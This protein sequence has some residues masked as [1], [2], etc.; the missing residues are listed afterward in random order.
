MDGNVFAVNDELLKKFD[1]IERRGSPRSRQAPPSPESFATI[2]YLKKQ[3]SHLKMQLA[4]SEER[5][6][7]EKSNTIFL[8]GQLQAAKKQL[9]RTTKVVTDMQAAEVHSST[10]SNIVPAVLALADTSDPSAALA[11]LRSWKEVYT[12]AHS[13]HAKLSSVLRLSN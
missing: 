8:K 13:L 12:H 11:I 7:L 6:A 10:G 9:K 2:E 4:E 5:A 3:V 1:N